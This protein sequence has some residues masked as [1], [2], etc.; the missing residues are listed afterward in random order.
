MDIINIE[1]L[2]HEIYGDA[3]TFHPDFAEEFVELISESRKGK[4]IIKQ[5]LRRLNAIMMNNNCD[6]GFPWL[7]HL[8]E[9]GNMYSLHIDADKT[10]F[11]LL[12]SRQSSGKLFLRMFY[13]KSGKK[14][15]SY[16]SHVQIAL[17]RRDS[18]NQE[19]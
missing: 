8:K 1:K 18:F 13:E 2:L 9:Y 11:R 15:T 3:F 14:A 12:F 7:E 4:A 19:V 5:F 17:K 6:Y 16:D 10:N